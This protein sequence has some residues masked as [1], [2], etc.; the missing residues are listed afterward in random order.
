[1]SERAVVRVEFDGACEPPVRGRMGYGFVVRGAGLDARGAGRVRPTP[2]GRSSNNIAE[3]AGA[4][5]GLEFLRDAGYRGPVLLVGDSQLVVRQMNGEYEVRAPHLRPLS[6][7]LRALGGRF[8]RLDVSWIPREQ[9]A[10][11]DALSK[12]GLGRAVPGAEGGP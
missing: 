4:I 9:N 8:A 3:Y 7:R 12:R 1:M 5:A 10:E 11:A 6:E 2:D